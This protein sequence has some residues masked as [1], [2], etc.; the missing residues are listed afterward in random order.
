VR[1]HP[2]RL[3][4][5]LAIA[6]LTVIAGAPGSAM[7]GSAPTCQDTFVPVRLSPGAPADYRVYGRLCLPA[8]PRPDT[9]QLLVSGLTYD[10]TYWDLP[11][12]RGGDRFSYTSS[13][14]HAGYATFAIDR[15]GVGR[16]SHPL[17]LSV[18][19]DSNSVSLHDVIQALRSGTMGPTGFHRVV[20]VGHSYG[21]WVSWYEAS[22]FHDVD[23]VILS[24]VSHYI[25]LTSPIRL[26][27]RLYPAAADSSY[28]SR[29]D[30]VLDPTYLTSLPGQR[31]TMFQEPSVVEPALISYDETH[32]QT[33]TTG[34]ID[35]F[36]LI[37]VRP[38][39]IRVPVLLANGSEDRLFCGLGG[40]D[41]SSASGLV[42][43]ERARLGNRAPSV[44]AY[45]LNGSGH[46]LNYDSHAQ[47]WFQAAQQWVQS[48]AR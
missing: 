1:S 17:G 24:G 37:L 45:V 13:A 23:A 26:L 16:S 47:Q 6:L 11:D 32:K 4:T 42:A 15:I 22:D 30:Q 46:D 25:N 14:L 43:S 9:V 21:S 2:R 19:I 3:L 8:G 7:A 29:T 48:V 36:A 35:N 27:T 28:T 12:P 44:R 40:A 18:T 39:D 31:Y 41:C 34:E 5:S 10:H 33:V 20:L 38:L